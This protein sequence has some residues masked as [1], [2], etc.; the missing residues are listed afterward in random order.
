[1]T[2]LPFKATVYVMDQQFNI[3]KPYAVPTLYLYA[4]YSS[5]IKEQIVPLTS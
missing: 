4:L 2:V 5:Q 1:M 3:H